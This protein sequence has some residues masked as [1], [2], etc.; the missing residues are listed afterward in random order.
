MTVEFLLFFQSNLHYLT[1][2]ATAYLSHA[3]K[4]WLKCRLEIISIQFESWWN[5]VTCPMTDAS[6]KSRE[7]VEFPDSLKAWNDRGGKMKHPCNYCDDFG[8]EP[9]VEDGAA[10]L[11][12][13]L[14]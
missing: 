2:D 11:A 10:L 13:S 14:Y 1:D 8:L 5:G 9:R 7:A 6:D 4:L 12:S 3:A